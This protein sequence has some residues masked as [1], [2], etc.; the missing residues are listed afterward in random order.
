VDNSFS[1]WFIKGVWLIYNNKIKM[2]IFN[3]ILNKE[4]DI[5]DLKVI[6]HDIP[7]KYGK[8][9]SVKCVEFTV[10]G[11]HHKWRNWLLYDDFKKA[12]KHIKVE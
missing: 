5:E 3:P 8:M 2:R 12:N 10:I 11:K 9:Q 6:F 4:E 1:K 7:D